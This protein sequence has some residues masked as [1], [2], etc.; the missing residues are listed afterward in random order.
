MSTMMKALRFVG[1]LD[2]DF[3]K[4]ERQRDVWNEASAVGFQL[5][6]WIALI[7]A[8]ILPWVAGRTGAW[9]SFGLIIGWF[10]CSMAVLRY[11]Q[12]HDVDVY[13]S[14]KGLDPRVL[15][16]GSVYVI[17]L[18]GVVAQLMARPGEGIAT[19]AGRGVGALIG[20]TAAVLVVKRHQRRAAL[21]D[22]A[23]E[24]L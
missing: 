9:I 19:W 3:Y 23:D 17:A 7:A 14:M 18:I 12:V 15:V 20:L 2:D 16:A 11:A 5:A 8:A 13:A 22:E 21:R 24:L 1:D 4:D 10:V 6:Y